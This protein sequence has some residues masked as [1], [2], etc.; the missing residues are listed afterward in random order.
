MTSD[1]AFENAVR[2]L[3]TAEAA[4]GNI[5]LME[6]YEKLADSWILIANALVEKE[7]V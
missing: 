7:R 6:R 4:S 5:A 1:E 2:L 3:T